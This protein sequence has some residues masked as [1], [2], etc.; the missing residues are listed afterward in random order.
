MLSIKNYKIYM[1][2][3]AFFIGIAGL[4]SVMAK[5]TIRFNTELLDLNDKSNI[6]LDK[7]SKANYIMPGSYVLKIKINNNVLPEQKI[8]FYPSEIDTDNTEACLDKEL[9][10]KVGFKPDIL[11]KLAWWNDGKCVDLNSIPGTTSS[12]DLSDSTL[13]LNIPQAYLDYRSDN[14]DPPSLWDEGI[15]GAFLDYNINAKTSHYK[16]GGQSYTANA[17]GIVG[18]NLGVWRFRADWQ[19]RLNHSSS[20]NSTTNTNFKWTRL[21]IFRAIKQLESKLLLGETYLNSDLFDSFRFTGANLSSDISMLP[22]NLRGYAPEITG[23]ANTNATVIISQEG[24]ILYQTQVAAG[25]FRIQNL[26]DITSGKLDVRIEEQDGS[27]RE[28]Q[29][30]TATIPYLTRPGTVRYKLS[31]GKPTTF[32]HRSEGDLFASGEFSWGVSNGWSLFGGSL[33]SQDYNSFAIGVGRDLLSLGAISFDVTQSMAKLPHGERLNGG[34]Y[35]VNYSKRFDEYDS[36]VQFAGYR[37][38]ERDFMS[39]SD[40]LDAKRQGQRYGSSKEMYSVSLNKNFADLRLSAYFNYDHL[41]YWDKPDDDRYN[42]MLTKI[43]DLDRIKNIN[44]SLSIYR[45]IYNKVKDDGAYLSVSLP[46]ADNANIGYSMATNRSETTN[47]ATYYDRINNNTSYQVSAGHDR[48][49]AIG[50]G[51]IINDNS[52]SSLTANFSYNHN[53]YTSVGLGAKGGFTLTPYGGDMHRISALGATRLLVDTDGVSDI[54]VRG[55][56]GVVNSNIFGK[57]IIPDVNS[58]YRNNTKV[59][60]NN[61]PDDSEMINSVVQATL[62]E[63]AIGYRKFEVISGKK[64]MITVQLKDGSYPPFGSQLLNSKGISTGIIN[65]DGQVYITGINENEHMTIHWGNDDQCTII[66]PADISILEKNKLIT[67][68]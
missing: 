26:S 3:L 47:Q 44:F 5:D 27:V 36:Q 10:N 64:M 40:Y 17:N 37:F 7:F 68:E 12:G 18:I 66:F 33:N 52:R 54:P 38:S 15:N 29:V 65:D 23:V 1:T 45:N 35:R 25:P 13:Q 6:D 22:P 30:N 58:Y 49:G 50:S 31:V 14:W 32:D 61:I 11:K 28:F 67:C 21:F 8:K 51:Y 42:L 57:A 34:S 9:A 62:T 43:I 53:S 48:R 46:W 60:L 19:T 20:S 39:M 59:D 24:R 55:N 16:Q 63:G 41:T 2:Y 56:S 4:P